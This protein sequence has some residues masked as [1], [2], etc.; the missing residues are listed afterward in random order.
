MRELIKVPNQHPVA[1]HPPV[2]PNWPESLAAESPYRPWRAE[3]PPIYCRHPDSPL[4][5]SCEAIDNALL[6]L[7][8]KDYFGNRL[9]C[10]SMELEFLVIGA[11]TL[12]LSREVHEILCIN[13]GGEADR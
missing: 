6:D 9:V 2:G 5:E 11:A 10:S 4:L 8:I 1:I 7:Q 12:V 13:Y 3:E